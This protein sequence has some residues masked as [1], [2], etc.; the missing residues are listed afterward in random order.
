MELFPRDKVWHPTTAHKFIAE[1]Q[2]N[3]Y[4]TVEYSWLQLSLAW[5]ENL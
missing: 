2:R 1:L 4:G 5:I 3:I